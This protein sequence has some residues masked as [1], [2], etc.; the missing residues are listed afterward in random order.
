[1]QTFKFD[2][3]LVL[4]L[5]N[6]DVLQVKYLGESDEGW[7]IVKPLHPEEG[8]PSNSELYIES[9]NVVWAARQA[10]QVAAAIDSELFDNIS[11]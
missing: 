4:K 10:A 11:H 7:L 3:P 2:E 1:M 8:I 5:I 9:K 6:G